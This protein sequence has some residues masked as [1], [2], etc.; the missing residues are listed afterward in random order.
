[1]ENEKEIKI[2]INSELLAYQIA[3]IL[4]QKNE[5]YI[6]NSLVYQIVKTQV[7]DSDL[8]DEVYRAT[9]SLLEDKYGILFDVDKKVDI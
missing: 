8:I 2:Y 5:R 6:D 4:N 7:N 1:M 3:G 9:I